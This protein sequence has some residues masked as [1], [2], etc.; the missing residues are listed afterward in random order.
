[1]PSLPVY[2]KAAHEAEKCLCSNRRAE[3]QVNIIQRIEVEVLVL[4]KVQDWVHAKLGH[5]E[6]TID[7]GTQ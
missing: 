4:A 7:V 1:M 2:D 5:V 3:I 6:C